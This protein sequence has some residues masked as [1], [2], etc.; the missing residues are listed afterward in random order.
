MLSEVLER[1]APRA[2]ETYLDGTFGAGGYSRAIL[3]AA[4]CRVVATDR[5]PSAVA[6][7]R[8]LAAARPDRF[9]I[10]EGAFGDMETLLAGRGIT[11]LDGVVLDI[12]VSSMQLDRPERGFSFRNDGPLDM[13]MAASGP[14]AADIVNSTDEHDLADLIWRYGDERLS[15]RIA[16]AI[17]LARAD[18][19]VERTLQL[20][21]IVAG[22]VRGE[23]G[24]HP[25]TRTFQA[26]R[27]VVNDE[28]G[29]L[30][31]GLEAAERLLR[32]MGRLVVVSFHSLED[33]IVKRFLERRAGKLDTASRHA[34]AVTARREPSFRLVPGGA[35]KAGA[36]ETA[37]NPRARSA[38]LRA[39]IRTTAPA[40]PAEEAA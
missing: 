14:T 24:Q 39:A 21:N 28:L 1:L 8:D 23:P 38:R 31:R 2:G 5:D 3:D 17:V 27:I 37:A 12:G 29:E 32:P 4:D 6:I 11:A 13:R 40:W 35:A 10:I 33:R 20:A 22:C 25:A 36:T 19:P 9:E 16:R 15:R 26:L 34:P 7:A 30:R 18:A